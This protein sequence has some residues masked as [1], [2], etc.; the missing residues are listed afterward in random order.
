MTSFNHLLNLETLDV[1]RNDLDS[2]RQLEC[3]RHLRELRADGN[4]IA[5]LEGLEKMDGL[6]KLSL[7]GNRISEVS[8][9]GF[10]WYVT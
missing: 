8:L 1:S 7:Q 10:Q 3:L 9:S 6:V 4:K 5:S 2:L